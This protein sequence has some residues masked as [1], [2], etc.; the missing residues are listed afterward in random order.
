MHRSRLMV[1]GG[2]LVFPVILGMAVAK[3]EQVDS[4]L[5]QPVLTYTVQ[6]ELPGIEP[7]LESLVVYDDGLSIYARSK[8]PLLGDQSTDICVLTTVSRDQLNQLVRDLRMA[9]ANTLVDGQRADPVT[10]AY[11]VTVFSPNGRRANTFSYGFDFIVPEYPE[12][13]QTI[14]EFIDRISP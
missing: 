9:S 14:G 5:R 7:F 4:D 1:V 3:Q 13:H 12:V 8:F 10:G 6:Q 2:L 11:T